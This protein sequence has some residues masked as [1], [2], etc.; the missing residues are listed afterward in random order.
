MGKVVLIT[1]SGAGIGLAT[2]QAFKAKG[3]TVVAS[4][5]RAETVAELRQKGFEAIQLDVTDEDSMARAVAGVLEKHKTVDVLVNNAGYSLPGPLE[6]V[7]MQDVRDIFETNVFGMLRMAQ[8]VL[9]AMRRQ[10][11][12]RIINIGS[13]G[14]TFTSIGSTAYHMTKYAV[15]S[16]SDGLRAEVSGFGVD[17]VLIQPGGVATRFIYT[18]NRGMLPDDPASPYRVFKANIVRTSEG[19]FEGNSALWG[20]LKPE[21]VARAIV[22]AAEARRPRTRYKVGLVARLLPRFLRLMSDRQADRF[23]QR[24]FPMS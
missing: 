24:Q 11:H 6:E 2:A 17:V 7:R 9:P 13:A 23:W 8:L 4:A 21:H 14:G 19:M 15:E 18:A 20:I 1:G 22:Q 12:G 3:Y 10:G 16:L 5:R